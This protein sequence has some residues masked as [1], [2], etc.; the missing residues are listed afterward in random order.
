MFITALGVRKVL[1]VDAR[2]LGL[3][4]IESF[5]LLR[6]RMRIAVTTGLP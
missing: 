6:F 1:L 4:P 2:S 5:V 3:N